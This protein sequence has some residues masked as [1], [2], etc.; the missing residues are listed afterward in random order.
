MLAMLFSLRGSV[1]LYQGEELG[2][3]EADVP[4]ERIQDPYGKVLWPEFK[5]R[6]GCR[7]PMPWTDGTQAGFSAIEPWLPVEKRHL[8]LAVSRQ[9]T[10]PDSTLNAVRR[11]LAF[12][13][14]HSALFDGDL[15]LI[16]VGEELLG[17]I[18]QNDQEKVLCVFNLTGNELQT[19]LPLDV[20]GDLE[21]HGFT[22]ARKGNVLTLPAYQA[23]FMHVA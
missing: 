20:I 12:R 6:D 13:Q 18:R 8:P 7:T 14:T 3:P 1:C 2:L 21:G 22:T 23:A 15:Q 10:N 4:F 17:F 9:Q 5:G 16:E 19:A 11:M